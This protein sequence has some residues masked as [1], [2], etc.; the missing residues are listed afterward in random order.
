[1][2]TNRLSKV[3]SDALN[4]QVTK[5]AHASQIYLSYA[6]WADRQG[7]TGIPTFLFRHAAE[8][9]DHMMKLLEYILQRGA[10]VKISAIPAPHENPTSLQN[11]FERIFEHETD[12]T[13][14][15]YKLVKLSHDEEDWAT[16]NFMQWF[17]EEQI[18]EETLAM[19]ILD[20]IKLAGGEKMN[21][22]ALYQLDKDLEKASGDER[23]AEE[24]TAV[25]P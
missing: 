13:K 14:A 16:L 18:E 8:E 25:N 19:S 21:H 6:S 11:C 22:N 12:N 5:E 17:V 9:R 7:F 3:L 24:V 4:A 15:I 1:M 20:K 23:P 10:E 2:N